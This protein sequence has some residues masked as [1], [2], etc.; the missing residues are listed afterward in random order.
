MGYILDLIL[1]AV[2]IFF[3]VLGRRWGAIR[4]AVEFL[5]LFAAVLA[6]ILIGNALSDWIFSALIRDSVIHSVQSAITESAGHA[7]AEQLQQVLGVLPGFVLNASDSAALSNEVSA[8]IAKGAADGA[9]WIVDQA[10]RPVVVAMLRVILAVLLSVVFLILIRLLARMLDLVAKLP[11]LRQLNH[12]LGGICGALKGA[13][14]ILLVLA[15][16]R[17][18]LPMG[19]TPGLLSQQNL[20]QSVLFGTVYENNPLAAALQP[21]QE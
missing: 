13:A 14:V 5:G 15:V 19:K 17:V 9:V 3:I 2:L 21:E 18:A 11:V 10:V 1:I 16:L 7:A 12:L 20:E 4:T 8:A 6:A